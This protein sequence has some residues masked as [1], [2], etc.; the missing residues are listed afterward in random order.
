[1][2]TPLELA[3]K[4][5]DQDPGP[6]TFPQDLVLHLKFGHV[7]S[8]PTIFLMGRPVCRL[9]D[10]H[11]ILDPSFVFI[12]P[13]AWFVWIAAGAT[14]YECLRQMPFYLPW[15]G[16]QRRNKWPRFYDTELIK[17][18]STFNQNGKR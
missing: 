8:S 3:Q 12:N 4:H 7:I 2:S 13:D 15:V 14:P 18:Y 10:P 6:R 1:M 9:A 16:W 5:Y 17:N 11:L